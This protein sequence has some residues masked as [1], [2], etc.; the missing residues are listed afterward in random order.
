MEKLW[1]ARDKDSTNQL[2]VYKSEPV[3]NNLLKV[4]E[5]NEISPFDEPILLYYELF[6]EVTWENS[7]QQIELKLVKN[8]EK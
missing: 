6:P 8:D 1:I 2:Y 5:A 3:R 4:F 7:P